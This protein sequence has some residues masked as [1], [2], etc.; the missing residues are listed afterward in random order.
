MTHI[1]VITG[2]LGA[3]K[4]TFIQRYAAALRNAGQKLLIIENE[5]GMAGIDGF[6]L[7][8]QGMEVRELAGGCICCS[9]RHSFYEYLQQAAAEGYERIIVE[10]SGVYDLDTLFDIM[11]DP[12]LQNL[13]RLDNVI[14]IVKPDLPEQLL[15]KLHGI[16]LSQLFSTGAI[17]LSNTQAHTPQYV[18]NAC[19]KLEQLARSYAPEFSLQEIPLFTQPWDDFS[20]EQWLAFSR[21]GHLSFAHPGFAQNHAGLYDSLT[22]KAEFA[23]RAA[24]EAF[25]QRLFTPECGNIQRV[26]GFALTQDGSYYQINCTP[27]C[28]LI[29]PFRKVY[30]LLN[31]LGTT[32]HQQAIETAHAENAAR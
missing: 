24:L 13:C 8:S 4:T 6:F 32:L 21:V 20:P 25:L 5:F 12:A 14:T 3:G 26:K 27:E 30:N 29:Q 16:A 1:D 15:P 23:D 7:K 22:L 19:R 11:I 28:R 17:V 10:P 9:Q 31:V 18:Q 2:F